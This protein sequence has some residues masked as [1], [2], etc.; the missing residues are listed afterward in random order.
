MRKACEK[1]ETPVTGGNVSFYN[2]ASMGGKVEPVYPTPTI[3][4]LGVLPDKKFLTGIGFKKPGDHIYLIGKSHND[5]NCSEYLY[6][7]HKVKLS[8]APVFDLEEEYRV[9]QIIM[10]LIQRGLLESCN[11]VSDGGLFVTLFESAHAGKNG[12]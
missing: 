11:D 5:I 4:M 9:Q 2:Q 12:V 1:F 3:G 8:P 7:Y 10:E 6:A